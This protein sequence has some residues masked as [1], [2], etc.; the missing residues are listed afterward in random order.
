ME[1]IKDS[2]RSR[3]ARAYLSRWKSPTCRNLGP[4]TWASFHARWWVV[5]PRVDLPPGS[6]QQGVRIPD[7]GAWLNNVPLTK[8]LTSRKAAKKRLERIRRLHPEARLCGIASVRREYG[9]V[10]SPC[11][12]SAPKDAPRGWWKPI[13]G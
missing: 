4:R 10:H 11:S 7:C 3:Q 12:I 6:I 8:P 2:I 9:P 13:E 1:A 5:L